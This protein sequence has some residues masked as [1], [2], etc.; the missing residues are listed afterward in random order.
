[1]FC[2]L[3]SYHVLSYIIITDSIIIDL[4][5]AVTG[6]TDVL[7]ATS[8]SLPAD[9]V[10][11]KT[12]NN[13]FFHFL[14]P[15]DDS[16][17]IFIVQTILP[18]DVPHDMV[19]LCVLSTLNDVSNSHYS[20]VIMGAMASQITSITIVYSTRRRSKKT[21]KVRVTG[22]YEGNSSVTGEF[23]AQMASNAENVS[24]WWRH[25]VKSLLLW[26]VLVKSIIHPI[27]ETYDKDFRSLCQQ[28]FPVEYHINI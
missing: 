6:G 15:V 22:L 2:I 9:T 3:I 10:L 19:G 23:H 12:Q 7:A 21:L 24:I 16:K 17:C 26:W 28:Y 14:L 11:N 5:W 25:H 27:P 4:N 1:M 8:A 20:D 13:S 18:D